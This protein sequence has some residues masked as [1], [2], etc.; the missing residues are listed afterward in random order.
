MPCFEWNR[1]GFEFLGFAKRLK[2]RI[3]C[4]YKSVDWLWCVLWVVNE[5]GSK[6]NANNGFYVYVT[7]CIWQRVYMFMRCIDNSSNP[8]FLTGYSLVP[9]QYRNE[10]IPHETVDN[11]S[12]CFITLKLTCEWQP[13]TGIATAPSH[14][15]IIIT[16]TGALQSM[17]FLYSLSRFFQLCVFFSV[18]FSLNRIR[19]RLLFVFHHFNRMFFFHPQS[20]RRSHAQ[21]TVNA[22]IVRRLFVDNRKN[23]TFDTFFDWKMKW[24]LVG[25]QLMSGNLWN[26]SEFFENFSYFLR[27]L[28]HSVILIW[29]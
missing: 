12:N 11:I 16:I 27:F 1:N 18:D 26:L 13:S 24:S 2:W 22:H 6:F 21:T 4:I 3:N 29:F 10:I 19:N 5:K 9:F 15:H 8:I 23:A 25:V 28:M 17:Q 14:H 7:A 20:K